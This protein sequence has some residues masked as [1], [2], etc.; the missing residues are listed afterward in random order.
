MR[1]R[2]RARPLESSEWWGRRH[3]DGGRK[4]RSEQ[5]SLVAFIL[6]ATR[7]PWRGLSE[8]HDLMFFWRALWLQSQCKFG[9]EGKWLWSQSEHDGA[10]QA[11][12]GGD[13]GEVD[14]YGG[15]GGA[16]TDTKN[17]G[18][19]GSKLGDVESGKEKGPGWFQIYLLILP[20]EGEQWARR[21]NIFLSLS[22]VYIFYLMN[23]YRWYLVW[24]YLDIGQLKII[25]WQKYREGTVQEKENAAREEGSENA[26]HLLWL[27]F[28]VF[29][30]VNFFEKHVV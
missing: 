2:R 8:G 5:W 9:D 4:D 28:L 6:S 30:W 17:F 3:R 10:G 23:K 22:M 19:K 26:C 27:R 12:D 1:W 13:G 21:Q 20:T 25:C 7:N 24:K 14:Y 15:S 16:R 18:R 11:G 29:I